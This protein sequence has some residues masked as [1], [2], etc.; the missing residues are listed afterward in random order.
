MHT[1]TFCETGYVGNEEIQIQFDNST[2]CTNESTGELCTV[3]TVIGCVKE[4]LTWY[5]KDDLPWNLLQA[6]RGTTLVQL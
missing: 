1:Y 4:M 5:R 3:V 2:Y 6:M